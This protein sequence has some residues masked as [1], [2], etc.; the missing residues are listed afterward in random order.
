MF[1]I[2]A[3]RI[4]QIIVLVSIFLFPA[5]FIVIIQIASFCINIHKK[6]NLILHFPCVVCFFVVNIFRLFAFFFD[7]NIIFFGI[8]CFF[9]AEKII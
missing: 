1:P 6:S 7:I 8:L 3:P 5:L 4:S 2:T 9:H